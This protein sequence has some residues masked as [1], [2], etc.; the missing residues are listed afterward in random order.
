MF[1]TIKKS[2]F[3]THFE[4]VAKTIVDNTSDLFTKK[5]GIIQHNITVAPLGC[6]SATID[7]FQCSFKEALFDVVATEE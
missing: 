3:I 6:E 2:C 4:T 5:K 1:L 7:I